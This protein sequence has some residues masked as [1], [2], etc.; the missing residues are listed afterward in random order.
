MKRIALSLFLI[1]LIA[2]VAL[3]LFTSYKPQVSTTTTTTTVTATTIPLP[4]KGSLIVMVKDV[5]HKVPLIG[6]VYNLNLTINSVEA[7]FVGTDENSTGQWIV[8]FSGTKTFDLLQYT[9]ISALIGEREL[10]PGKYTQIR[11]NL[12]D[13]SFKFYSPFYTRNMTYPLKVPSKELKITHNFN[14]EQ[15]KTAVLT[16]DFDVEK[17]LEKGGPAEYLLKPTIKILEESFP[18]GQRPSNSVTV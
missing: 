18:K 2:V 16:L 4:E 9:N 3:T 12:S 15:N 7:H 1:V 11:L 6:T 13:S 8:I 5:S 10:T 17:S 14:I